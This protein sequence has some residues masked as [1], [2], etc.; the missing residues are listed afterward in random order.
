MAQEI[1]FDNTL[2]AHIDNIDLNIMT[3]AQDLKDLNLLN[4]ID[5]IQVSSNRK[6]LEIYTQD[7]TA[8]RI[9]HRKSL[10]TVFYSII[11]VPKMSH[12]L[13]S[14]WKYQTTW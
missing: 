9:I 13:L 3:L 5:G 14:L 2:T 6:V 8:K 4:A 10:L 12:F 11:R 7:E 1:S